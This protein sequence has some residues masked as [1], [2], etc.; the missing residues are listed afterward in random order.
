MIYQ[1]C[2]SLGRFV[3]DHYTQVKDITFKK[4]RKGEFID[5]KVEEDKWIAGKIVDIEFMP[6]TQKTIVKVCHKN[7]S[8]TQ[9]R[10]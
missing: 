4:F 7:S 3:I 6:Y 2:T 8:S 1:L 9:T 10:K 5:C